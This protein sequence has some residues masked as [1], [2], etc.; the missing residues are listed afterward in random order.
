MRAR[1]AS[2]MPGPSSSTT[3]RTRPFSAVART[4]TDS[5]LRRR[6]DRVLNEVP[7]RREELPAVVGDQ[8]VVRKRALDPHGALRGLRLEDL[9]DLA[10]ELARVERLLAADDSAASR[11]EK[12]ARGGVRVARARLD[13]GERA[14][15]ACV[16][17]TAPSRERRPTEDR[18][19][20]VRE[21]VGDRSA[22]V[23]RRGAPVEVA[24]LLH[25]RR[26]EH[27]DRAGAR[28]GEQH[29]K[30][31]E[32]EARPTVTIEGVEHRDQH[33]IVARQ[34]A[35]ARERFAEA[36]R[37]RDERL[38]VL[39]RIDPSVRALFEPRQAGGLGYPS[40][41]I[42]RHQKRLLCP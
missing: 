33:R 30:A 6:L 29:A 40:Q 37:P 31:A 26:D 5:A 12:C 15:E 13:E 1:S 22:Q 3:T 38:G 39:A 41:R 19:E 20:D 27:R 21:L 25:G 32:V 2:A 34:I 16:D 18:A 9:H 36:R 28:P 14:I 17:V 8:E 11:V 42:C 23:R 10:D 24:R 4:R 7:E 35:E